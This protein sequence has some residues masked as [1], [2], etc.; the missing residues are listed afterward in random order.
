MVQGGRT[1]EHEAHY[2][3]LYGGSHN[4][5]MWLRSSPGARAVVAGSLDSWL[6]TPIKELVARPG[7]TVQ[8]PV[9]VHRPTGFKGEMGLVINGPTVSARCSL[10]VP[11]NLKANE[12]EVMAPLTIDPT[13]PPGTRGIVVA[14][15]WASDL[16]AGRPG[17]CTP[18]IQLRVVPSDSGK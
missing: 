18:L 2:L 13:T 8:I 4:D 7:Q 3:T 5:G 10:G 11:R 9:K 1:I 12:T 6:E 16:R 14:Q 15:S 17:P